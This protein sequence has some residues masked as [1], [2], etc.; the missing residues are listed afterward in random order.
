[1]TDTDIAFF[2]RVCAKDAYNAPE[3][4]KSILAAYAPVE[5]LAVTDGPIPKEYR[6]ALRVLGVKVVSQRNHLK[7]PGYCEKF[8]EFGYKSILS[9]SKAE[10]FIQVDPDSR[11]HRKAHIPEGDWV[12]QVFWNVNYRILSTV[13]AGDI[14]SR[15]LLED[16]IQILPTESTDFR[17]E[18]GVS[19]DTCMGYH[20][21]KLGYS[22]T[23]WVN[24]D[25]W[26][27]VN[28]LSEW[29]PT[30]SSSGCAITHPWTALNNGGTDGVLP[31]IPSL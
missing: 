11:I 4:V 10:R 3:M 6:E 22:P 19:D 18:K 15:K 1:M 27:E 25:G 12:G 8:L 26:P 24:P 9:L 14:F 20:L 5:V 31:G 30:L 23:P 17:Y 21:A 2:F 28:L 16:L 13:G 29:S 7:R